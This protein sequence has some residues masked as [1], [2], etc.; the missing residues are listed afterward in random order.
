MVHCGGYELE[1]FLTRKNV[2]NV[3]LRICADGSVRVSANPRVAVSRTDA[4]VREKGEW[5]LRKKEEFAR[6]AAQKNETTVC[7]GAKTLFLGREYVLRI[8]AAEKKSV[9]ISEDG[10]EIEIRIPDTADL[11]LAKKTLVRWYAARAAEILPE[12]FL[13]AER[14]TQGYFGAPCLLRLRKMRARWGSCNAATRTVTLNTALV[15]APRECIRYVALHE[16]SHIY[17]SAHD[18]TFYALLGKFCPDWKTVRKRL[19]LTVAPYVGK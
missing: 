19:N 7:D 15:H 1:Y 6:R 9:S 13:S 4:F 16:L 14:E 10:G 17:V 2:K 18:R 8:I 3:N 5:V 12:L 11:Q